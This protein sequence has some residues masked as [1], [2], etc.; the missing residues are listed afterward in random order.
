MIFDWPFVQ[1]SRQLTYPLTFFV[2]LAYG[3]LPAYAADAQSSSADRE[4]FVEIVRAL[5]KKPLPAN[6]DDR[7]WAIRWLEDV[8]DISVKVCAE[9]LGGV[10][11][12]DYPHSADI[13]VQYVLA[14]AA[15]VIRHPKTATDEIAQQTAGV[16]SALIAYRAM[17]RGEPSVRSSALENLLELKAQG[18][19]ADFVRQAY[20]SCMAKDDAG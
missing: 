20:D 17:Y 18:K 6:N 4:R 16:E 2:F 11:G 1:T 19:L 7:A 12:S 8:P 9:P 15:N 13:T 14:M 3:A 5:E 10:V